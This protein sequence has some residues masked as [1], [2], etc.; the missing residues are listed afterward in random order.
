MN[1][2]GTCFIGIVDPFSDTCPSFCIRKKNGPDYTDDNTSYELE[3]FRI[4]LRLGALHG[5]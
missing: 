3:D 4:R 1:Y 5:K 2:L